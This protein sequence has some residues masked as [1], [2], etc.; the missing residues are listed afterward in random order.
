VFDKHIGLP[1]K[2]EHFDT[3]LRIFTGTVK[4]LFAGEKADLAIS[5]AQSIAFSFRHKLRQMGRL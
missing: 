1:L 2:D 4:T 3:W 5:R